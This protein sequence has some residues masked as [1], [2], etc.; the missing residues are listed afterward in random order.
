PDNGAC[1]NHEGGYACACAAETYGNGFFCKES[2]S[3]SPNPCQNGGSC[4]ETPTSFVCQCPLGT[5]GSTC[6]DTTSCAPS[7]VLNDADSPIVSAPV[8]RAA[9]H[10]ATGI[11][12]P[13]AIHVS[14]LTG[15]T[16][17]FVAAPAAEDSAEAQSLDGLE[18]WTTLETFSAF[19]HDL[20]DLSSLSHLHR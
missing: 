13:A 2:S 17:L 9:L 16:A 5:V 8:I 20:S 18:C 14:D 3:C 7:V 4:V 19:Q 10:T 15:V 12:P 6:S 11:A 1:T